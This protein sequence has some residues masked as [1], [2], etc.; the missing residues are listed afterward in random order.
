[1][2]GT[3]GSTGSQSGRYIL[4]MGVCGAGKSH[5]AHALAE[6]LGGAFVEGDAFHPADNVQRMASGRPLT[7]AMRLPWLQAVAAAARRAA[8]AMPENTAAPVVIA[9]SALK[10]AYRDLLRA[11]LPGLA[12]VHLTGDRDVIAARMARRDGHFMPASMLD[13]QLADL[14]VPGKDEAVTFDVAG[15]REAVVDRVIQFFR[16]S[17]AEDGS[18]P[19]HESSRA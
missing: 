12:I 1:M 3:E 17:T 19:R 9:C 2:S 11:H 8:E 4:V 15:S 6:A 16:R 5:V 7:D 14:E 18:L 10:R 13:S